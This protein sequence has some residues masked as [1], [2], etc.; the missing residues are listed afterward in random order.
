MNTGTYDFR[1]PGRLVIWTYTMPSG[2]NWQVRVLAVVVK[3]T[4]KRVRVRVYSERYQRWQERSVQPE[5]LSLPRLEDYRLAQVKG[6]VFEM[7]AIV[8]VLL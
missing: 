2:W 6:F 8:E 4:V 5:H 3:R 1:Q 7:P